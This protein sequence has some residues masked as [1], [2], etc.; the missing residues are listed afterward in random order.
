MR[1]SHPWMVIYLSAFEMHRLYRGV[2]LHQEWKNDEGQKIDVAYL[3][4]SMNRKEIVDE[5]PIKK[6]YVRILYVD[7]ALIWNVKR[8]GAVL[9][10]IRC[11]T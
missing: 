7:G 5:L 3:F 2:Y 8:K 1:R 10:K 4:K 6:E 11:Y 9:D